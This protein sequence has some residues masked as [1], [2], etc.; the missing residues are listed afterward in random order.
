[1]KFRDV[2]DLEC[3]GVLDDLRRDVKRGMPDDEHEK[4]MEVVLIEQ[5]K[6]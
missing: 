5:R 1:M 2:L 4:R 3:D 6:G